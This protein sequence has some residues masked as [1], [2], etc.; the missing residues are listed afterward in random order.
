MAY[1]GKL[2]AS[3]LRVQKSNTFPAA[4]GCWESQACK[5]RQKDRDAR[6]RRRN[7]QT[8]FQIQAIATYRENALGPSRERY[9]PLP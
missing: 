7:A 6:S 4:A 5:L 3:E 9:V 2:R 1:P 8:T